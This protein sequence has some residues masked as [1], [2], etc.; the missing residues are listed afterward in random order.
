MDCW[1]KGDFQGWF[2]SE[3][4]CDRQSLKDLP[5]V[6]TQADFIFVYPKAPPR[7][8]AVCLILAS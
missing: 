8:V 4:T 3:T 6:F 7:E 1:L 2:L 5:P